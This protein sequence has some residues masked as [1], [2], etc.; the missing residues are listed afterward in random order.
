MIRLLMSC[1]TAVSCAADVNG[2]L[3]LKFTVRDFFLSASSFSSSFFIS[4]S[5]VCCFAP[6]D[7]F[8]IVPF[9][10]FILSFKLL[11]IPLLPL[12]LFLQL[13]SFSS[14]PYTH[15]LSLLSGC[16]TLCPLSGVFRRGKGMSGLLAPQFNIFIIN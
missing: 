6:L 12:F 11:L 5:L 7:S 9:G 16:H 13:S 4:L 15:F 3:C 8:Y 10:A 14:V 1:T 2:P